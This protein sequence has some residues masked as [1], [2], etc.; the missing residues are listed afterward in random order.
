MTFFAGTR[1]LVACFA[2][3]RLMAFFAG[4]RFLLACFAGARLKAFFAGTRFDAAVP[5]RLT[6]IRPPLLRQHTAWI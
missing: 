4:T 6:A 5:V 3:A 2:G 1:F